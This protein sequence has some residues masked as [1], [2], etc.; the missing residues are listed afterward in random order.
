MTKYILIILI[1]AFNAL[2]QDKLWTASIVTL[3]AGIGLDLAS[4]YGEYEANPHLR[5]A[6]GRLGAKGVAVNIG[7]V[8]ALITS[9]LLG[10]RLPRKLKRVLTVVNFSF[11]GVRVGIATRNW[12]LQ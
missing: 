11:T 8:S 12:R 10:K 2:A 4:S 6:D 9:R 7:V 3:T 5:G 1:L